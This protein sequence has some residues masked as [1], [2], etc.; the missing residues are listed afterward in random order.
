MRDRELAIIE[1]LCE[2]LEHQD[3]RLAA[4]EKQ[5]EGLE[6]NI[7]YPM[8]F[9]PV[10]VVPLPFISDPLKP[11]YRIGDFPPF[12]SYTITVGDQVTPTSKADMGTDFIQEQ[13]LNEMALRFHKS[14]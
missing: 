3:R 14:T 8:V 10:T 5:L 9:S 11:P 6:Q 7:K 2:L 12:G 1:H 13:H 4:I